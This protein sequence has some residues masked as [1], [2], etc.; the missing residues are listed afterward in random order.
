MPYREG[1]QDQ[2]GDAMRMRLK[3]IEVKSAKFWEITVERDGY[4]VHY[5]RIGSDAGRDDEP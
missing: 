2:R 5:G 4:T 3:F 1:V